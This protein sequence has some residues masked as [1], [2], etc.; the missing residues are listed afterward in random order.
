MESFYVWGA[1]KNYIYKP[2]GDKI[3]KTGISRSDKMIIWHE[4]T[5]DMAKLI[6]KND[7]SGLSSYLT[8]FE[9]KVLSG[10]YRVKLGRPKALRTWEEEGNE[11]IVADS[12][13]GFLES[14]QYSNQVFKKKFKMGDKPTFFTHV[15]YVEGYELPSNG[16][17]AL[18]FGDDPEDF[19]VKIDYKGVLED[20]IIGTRAMINMLSPLGGWN[21]IKN[22]FLPTSKNLNDLW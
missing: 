13:K 12:L 15:K 8:A 19:G 9:E 22:G 18:D 5:D 1:K 2:F 17:I 7:I 16:M 3:K 11:I 4:L 6:L 20:D 14:I 21:N 10:E